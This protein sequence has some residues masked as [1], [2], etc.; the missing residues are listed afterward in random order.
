MRRS[1][2]AAIAPGFTTVALVGRQGTDEPARLD[3]ASRGGVPKQLESVCDGLRERLIQ[4][5]RR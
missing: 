4:V 3:L 2:T 1:R 5:T